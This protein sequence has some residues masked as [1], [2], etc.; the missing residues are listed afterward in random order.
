MKPK[1]EDTTAWQQAEVLMQP[2][3]I[4]LV[5]RV[6]RGLDDSA[7]EGR[8]EEVETPIPGY[9]LCLQRSQQ[10]IRVDVWELCYQICF[11]PY[12]PARIDETRA[13]KI[14]TSLLDRDGEIDWNRLDA[15]AGEVVAKMLAALP[16]ANASEPL[17]DDRNAD[18]ID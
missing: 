4:R 10:E 9:S 12:A 18:K 6:R 14:D 2:A 16:E 11:L 7:W 3:L 15:K 5:D 8:Y 1:F 13:V 17:P